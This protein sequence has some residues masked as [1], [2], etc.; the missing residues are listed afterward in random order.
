MNN[1]CAWSCCSVGYLGNLTKLLNF[2]CSTPENIHN[3]GQHYQ[4]FQYHCQRTPELQLAVLHIICTRF[5][6]SEEAH[7]QCLEDMFMFLES[8]DVYVITKSIQTVNWEIL[9]LP[10][11][12]SF[13]YLNVDALG[14]ISWNLLNCLCPNLIFWFY[15]LVQPLILIFKIFF[16]Y[17]YIFC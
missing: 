16:L 13:Y 10:L 8:A 9:R 14:P 17:I 15:S 6:L 12:S 3:C 1:L 5:W 2:P 4:N 11:L 7:A